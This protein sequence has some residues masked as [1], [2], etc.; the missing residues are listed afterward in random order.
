MIVQIVVVMFNL[1]AISRVILRAR[2]GKITYFSAFFWIV[3][4]A[5]MMVLV[6]MPSVMVFISNLAG[7]Q[8]GVDLFIY[9]SIIVLFYFMFKIFIMLEKLEQEITVCVTE[10]ALMENETR[11]KKSCGQRNKNNSQLD[12]LLQTIFKN[13]R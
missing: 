6:L 1:F 9:L 8:R 13:F 5:S 3:L 4:F 10:I 7:V 11:T 12:K 2:D